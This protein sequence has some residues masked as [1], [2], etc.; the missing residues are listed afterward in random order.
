M[1]PVFSDLP[2]SIFEIMSLE[3]RARGAIN[4]G[5]GFPEVDGFADVREAAG[6]ALMTQSNQ[7][8]PMRGLPI[9]RNA[10]ADFYHRV[11]GVTVDPDTQVLITSG[12][13]E[14]ICAAIISMVTPGDEVVVFEPMYDAYVPLIRRAGGVPR[15][16]Q[17]RPP[18]W[19]FSDDDLRN[20]FSDRTKL[21]LITTPN[22]PT[23]H[24]FSR[25]QLTLL[26]DYCQRFDAWVMSDE[27]WEEVVFDRA[28]V[29]VLHIPT[30][31]QRAIKI[32]SA[33]KIFSLTGWKVGFVV[34]EKALI[35][36]VA[37]AHQFITFATPPAL[38]HA[39]AYG[40]GLPRDRFEA[41]RAELKS[42]RD[43]L[44]GLLAE[45]G[46]ARLPTEGTYFLNIDLA[47]SG[48]T[49]SG[50]DFAYRLVREQ[51]LATIP[52]QA[53]CET[54]RDLPVLR[55]CFAKA[56]DSLTRGAAALAAARKAN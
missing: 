30:L 25:E 7:Y 49:G 18:H 46:F 40:L 48:V 6:R 56:R 47:A 10:V 9:L 54:G 5:Q 24:C 20:V 50:L 21:V 41:A 31:A 55:L 3:A 53:F 52:L 26:G 36:Q 38:Q 34:A 29:S 44:A 8:A 2:V 13:T 42:Q 39:V 28:H 45:A 1:N 35:D 15:I 19:E 14:A 27:V 37:R 17:L 51:G 23:T 12:A 32:G 22:N 4:L 16:V 11:Q 33:G 43:Y